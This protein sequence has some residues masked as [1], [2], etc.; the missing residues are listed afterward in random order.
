MGRLGWPGRTRT[1]TSSAKR[2]SPRRWRCRTRTAPR[3]TARSAATRS[4][5][6]S[7]LCG[8][9]W[10]QRRLRW[11][12]PATP[13]AP[14]GPGRSAVGSAG[15]I[16]T[17]TG[18]P[19]GA[20]ARAAIPRCELAGDVA[21]RPTLRLRGAFS[22]LDGENETAGVPLSSIA[23]VKTVGRRLP[24]SPPALRPLS[25]PRPRGYAGE[26]DAVA[27]RYVR[28]VRQVGT[29]VSEPL[30]RGAAACPLLAVGGAGLVELGGVNAAQPNPLAGDDEPAPVEA[31]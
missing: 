4:A 10:W 17:P 20:E 12:C 14:R 23:P 31:P 13:A 5:H 19:S 11:R 22:L 25:G 2:S 27:P 6:R 8:R 26:G 3:R 24:G 21:F 7:P 1:P 28:P 9:G 18:S 29:E 15:R 30:R 16:P